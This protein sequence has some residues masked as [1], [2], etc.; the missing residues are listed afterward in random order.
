MNW[1]DSK[2]YCEAN[3]GV[4]F[5]A[6]NGTRAQ[7]DQIYDLFGNNNYWV[8]IYTIN[9]DNWINIK[10][11]FLFTFEKKLI[12]LLFSRTFFKNTIEKQR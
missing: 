11:T 8:G 12:W 6:V 2:A 3:E 10:G 7:L 4:L 1:D 5:W 9:F